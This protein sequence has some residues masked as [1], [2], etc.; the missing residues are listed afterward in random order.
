M[1]NLHANKFIYLVDNYGNAVYKLCQNLTFSKEDA[2]DL[3]QETFLKAIENPKKI[4]A[5]KEQGYLF[6][7]A[8]FIWKSTKRKYA[9]RNRIAPT[10][11]LCE[12]VHSGEDIEDDFIKREELELVRKLVDS[13][14][15]KYKIST[16]L[17]YSMEMSIAQIAQTLHLPSGTVKS[18]LFKARQIIERG[19]SHEGQQ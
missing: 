8:L 2:E 14:P 11:E 5:G 17:Y 7:T 18:R 16:I 9:R 15:E 1:E 19:I 10:G 4:V 6:S 3:F 12:T 13:L